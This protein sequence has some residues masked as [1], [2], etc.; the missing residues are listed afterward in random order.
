MPDVVE[1]TNTT[2]I[3]TQQ[4]GL[5]STVFQCYRANFWL[6]WRIVMPLIFFSFL[7][8]I[9]ATLLDSAVGSKDLWRFDTARGLFT[10]EYPR[11][12][13]YP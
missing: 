5:M 13:C 8:E 6:F 10:G 11:S 9:G 1:N 12:N 3:Q 4:V 2:D 7:F